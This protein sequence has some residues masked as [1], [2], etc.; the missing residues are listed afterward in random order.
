M[1]MYEYKLARKYAEA[2]LNTYQQELSVHDLKNIEKLGSDLKK[3]AY[4]HTYLNVP[5]GANYKN[6]CFEKVFNH[7]SIAQCFYGL[8]NLLIAHHRTYLFADALIC[9]VKLFY[10]RMGYVNFTISS[11]HELDSSMVEQIHAFIKQ[12]TGKKVL[13]KLK[14]DPSL[15]AGIRMSSENM[16]WENSI[17]KKLRVV[18]QRLHEEIL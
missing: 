16:V 8:T 5:L 1:I 9:I 7:Y 11:S 14:I 18:A 4:L 15:I 6:K 2:F 17:K 13:S 3:K 12:L 10:L